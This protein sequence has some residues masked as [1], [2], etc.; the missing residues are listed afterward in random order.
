MVVSCYSSVLQ[1]HFHNFPPIFGNIGCPGR[2]PLMGH[3][4]LYSQAQNPQETSCQLPRF[5]KVSKGK[6][7]LS[8]VKSSHSSGAD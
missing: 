7:L 3:T 1:L 8:S 5:R 4:F 2:N 6:V